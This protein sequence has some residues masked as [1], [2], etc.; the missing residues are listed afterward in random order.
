MPER[1][2]RIWKWFGTIA[3]SSLAAVDAALLMHICHE[4]TKQCG[5]RIHHYELSIITSFVYHTAGCKT[6]V[7]D[8]SHVFASGKFM[9]AFV[10]RT[11]ALALQATIALGIPIVSGLGA[12]W[13]THSVLVRLLGLQ[14][15][16]P[17]KSDI[18]PHSPGAKVRTSSTETARSSPASPVVV[19]NADQVLDLEEEIPVS[20]AKH[21]PAKGPLLTSP[22]QSPLLPDK[23]LTAEEQSD[24]EE[25]IREL[26]RQVRAC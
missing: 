6:P 25:F 12:G 14:P 19:C 15:K 22:I 23:E 5:N 9:F 11:M 20:L 3:L 24:L 21:E 1:A 4:H 10:S 18:L 16:E 13:L 7:L 8:T 17:Q 2:W 26:L